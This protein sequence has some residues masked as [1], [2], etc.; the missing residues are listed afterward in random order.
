[1]EGSEQFREFLKYASGPGIGAIVGW[2]TSLFLE[3]W[4]WYQNHTPKWKVYIAILLYLFV[5]MAAVTILV[6]LGTQP[7]IDL[8]FLGL[9]AGLGAFMGSQGSHATNYI[10]ES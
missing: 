9:S 1:M 7:T 4:A 2:I 6:A 8:Y 3:D 5:P 10:R